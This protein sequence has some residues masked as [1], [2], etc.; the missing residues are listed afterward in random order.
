MRSRLLIPLSA[1]LLGLAGALGAA[2]VLYRAGADALEEVLVARLRAAGESAALLA[3]SHPPTAAELRALMEV[4]ALEGAYCVT[5]EL[6]VSADATGPARRRVDLLRTDA[7][8]VA[9][10]LAGEPRIARSYHLGELEV[11]AGYFPLRSDGG[12]VHSVLVLEAGHAFASARATLTHALVGGAALALVGALALGLVAARWAR[13]ARERQEAAARAARGEALSKM[14]A[15]AAHEIRNPLGVIRGTVELMIERAS[16][17]LSPRD[18]T[19]LEDVL[20]EVERLRRLTEDLLDLSVDRPLALG[21]LQPQVLLEE[22]V[23]TTE[24]AFP[25]IR[26]RL[27]LE[28]EPPELEGDAGRLRQVFANLLQNAAQAQGQGEVRLVAGLDGAQLVVRVEDDGPGVPGPIR[29]RLFDPFVTGRESGTGLGLALCR[30]LV[31]R[32][33]GTL[34]LVPEARQGSTFEVRLPVRPA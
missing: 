4:N 10:A 5:P 29:A 31:E 24:A 2:L 27:A 28:G 34:R 20:G 33:G 26:V 32:H 3:G 9:L 17:T 13:D 6:A 21:A 7:S 22:A 15:M 18:R 30:R 11:M 8:Q 23:R 19:G 16:A 14:A 12:K 1:A 25:G